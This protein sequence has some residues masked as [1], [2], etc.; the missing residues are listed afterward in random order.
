VDGGKGQLNKAV[1]VLDD[2]ELRDKV[3]VV[4]LAKQFEEIFVPGRSI[5]I[6]LSHHSQGL[7]LIQRIR[8]EAHRFAIS[9]H[10]NQRVKKGVASRL[11][12]IPGIGPAKRKALLN[13]FGSIKKIQA[14][15]IEELCAING[16]NHTLA[17]IIKAEL[18]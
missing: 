15:S 13:Q 9:S 3:F 11:D 1:T 12:A 14:A 10:R 17:E 8:D 7:F 18:A 4:G 2:Y 5:P 6:R 16:I